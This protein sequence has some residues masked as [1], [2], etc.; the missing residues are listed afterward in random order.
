MPS[1]IGVGDTYYNRCVGMVN[2][3]NFLQVVRLIS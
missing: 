2:G 3:L 1:G